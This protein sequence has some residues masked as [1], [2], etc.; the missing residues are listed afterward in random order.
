MLLLAATAIPCGLVTFALLWQFGALTALVGAPFGGS[1]SALLVGLVLAFRQARAEQKSKRS[2]TPLHSRQRRQL[3]STPVRVSPAR[4]T[5]DQ[6]AR[7]RG[8]VT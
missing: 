2:V 3:K 4:P 1:F 7:S 8:P 5:I 6:P